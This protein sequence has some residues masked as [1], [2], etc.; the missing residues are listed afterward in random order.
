MKSRSI[1]LKQARTTEGNVFP[2]G[3]DLFDNFFEDFVVAED[4]T[5]LPVNRKVPNA[6]QFYRHVYQ[7]WIGTDSYSSGPYY[8]VRSGH[9]GGI[10]YAP[11]PDQNVSNNCV[12]AAL[13]KFY[14][15]VR[16]T[17]DISVDAFQA[18]QS[19]SLLKSIGA[20][21][22]YVLKHNPKALLRDWRLF[23]DLLKRRGGAL[24]TR[25]DP[26]TGR[27]L[28]DA[29]FLKEYARRG[30]GLW[31]GYSYG[32]KPLA[33][34]VYDS[35]QQMTN[36][37][38]LMKVEARAAFK[39]RYFREQ[40]NAC[41]GVVGTQYGNHAEDERVEF[42]AYFGVGSTAAN[43][44]SRMTS[45]NPASILWEL[46]PWSFVLDWVVDIGGFLRNFESALLSR[47]IFKSGTVTYGTRRSFAGG[48]RYK[49]GSRTV[50]ASGYQWK[51]WKRRVVLTLPPLP[52]IPTF[53]A[54]FLS[55]MRAA[56]AVALLTQFFSKGKG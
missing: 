53:K 34:T 40:P 28:F 25:Y 10:P 16:N 14:D 42:I 3:V 37:E 44:L 39:N 50:S 21:V 22:V 32:L 20:V 18:R 15:K 43:E 48:F 30:G 2:P 46:T 24:N 19:K 49:D 45:L 5:G 17:I 51:N 29:D 35:Y 33:Q 41:G 11:G 52:R 36:V 27:A 6:H 31:L 38:P 9:L 7:H 23:N 26:K 47:N 56:N 55:P 13:S 54:D 8:S 12:N 4:K 1:V